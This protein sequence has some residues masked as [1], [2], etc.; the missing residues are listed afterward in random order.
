MSDARELAVFVIA[1]LAQSERADRVVFSAHEVAR[2][3]EVIG[4]MAEDAVMGAVG[5]RETFRL[6]EAII[7]LRVDLDIMGSD[8]QATIDRVSKNR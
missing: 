1:K 2:I 4:K 7:Q 5:R 8:L 3:A 6:F